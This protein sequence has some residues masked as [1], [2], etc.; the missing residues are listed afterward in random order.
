MRSSTSRKPRWLARGGGL[1]SR[2][3]SRGAYWGRVG[4]VAPQ[5]LTECTPEPL[6]VGET[7]IVFGVVP[8][9]PPWP[10]FPRHG[11]RCHRA[12]GRR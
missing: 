4:L 3:P 6:T 5:V 7:S 11:G 2:S 12:A 9:R 8:E 10:S 1:P